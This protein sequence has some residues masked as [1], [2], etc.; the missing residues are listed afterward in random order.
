MCADIAYAYASIDWAVSNLPPFQQRMQGW[1]DVNVDLRIENLDSNPTHNLLVAFE[2][3]PIPLEFSVEFGAY[4][5]SIRSSLDILA[6]TLA[7]RNDMTNRD[8]AYFPIAQTEAKFLA[9]EYKGADFVKRLP[10][11]ERKII[12][13]IKPYD[14]G[15]P[16]LWELHNLDN[17][18]KHKRLLAVETRPAIVTG[19]GWDSFIKGEAALSELVHANGETIL[20]MV[21]KL[22]H[23]ND[24]K[25]AAQ[26]TMGEPGPLYGDNAI[27]ALTSLANVAR[28]IIKKF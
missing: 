18:R 28:D 21:S 26:I 14:G 17:A 16:L 11:T 9:R 19:H 27:V 3:A 20:G 23:K 5:N 8:K 10:D 1:L 24:F 2:K 7:Y 22:A 25:I 6:T 4:I 12:E 13:S 15:N